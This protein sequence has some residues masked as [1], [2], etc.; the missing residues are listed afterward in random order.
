MK[1]NRSALALSLSNGF[2]LIEVMV[3]VT[4]L[5]TVVVAV[6]ALNVKTSQSAELARD[7]V[8]ASG[9][10]QY[11]IEQTRQN[12]NNSSF[13]SFPILVADKTE[14]KYQITSV[15]EDLAP[16]KAGILVEQSGIYPSVNYLNNN[17]KK[18]IVTVSWQGAGRTNSVQYATFF[19]N[20]KE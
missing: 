4:I 2:G 6:F 5:V 14:G 8:V 20:W 9:W 17:L 12:I 18:Y 16:D 10:A 1:K 3:A 19:T 13:G 7:K 11:Y 15:A